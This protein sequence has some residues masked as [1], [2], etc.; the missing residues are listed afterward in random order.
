M[1]P[2]QKHFW[3][4]LHKNRSEIAIIDKDKV[5]DYGR[6]E[7]YILY[8][9]TTY[10]LDSHIAFWASRSFESTIFMLFCIMNMKITPLL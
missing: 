5:I 3:E 1:T 4:N 2:Y 7:K 6:L 10:D 8:L 9:N